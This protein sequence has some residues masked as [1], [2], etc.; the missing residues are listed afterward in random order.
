LLYVGTLH[1]RRKNSIMLHSIK[2]VIK[3]FPEIKLTIVGAGGDMQNLKKLT[4]K[5]SLEKNVAFV[6]EI[7]QDK[8]P[9]YIRNSD[10]C[11]AQYPKEE[12]NIQLPF[13]TLEYIACKKPVI[14]TITKSTKKYFENN[15][16]ILMVNF[17]SE[18]LANAIIRLIKDKKLRQKIAKEG[19]DLSKNFRWEKVIEILRDNLN[20]SNPNHSTN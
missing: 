18:E 10:I 16:N 2:K 3:T 19:L 15:K 1:P 13:K 8:V 7:S 5:L 9:D 4:K 14:T 12:F 11:L 6:G 17:N 20:N